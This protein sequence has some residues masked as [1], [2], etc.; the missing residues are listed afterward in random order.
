MS[1]TK[2]KHKLPIQVSEKIR[3]VIADDHLVYQE[4]LVL[5]INA[6]SDMVIIGEVGDGRQLLQQVKQ[7]QPDVDT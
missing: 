4:G 7:F 6:N 5:D 1:L 3:V 2:K